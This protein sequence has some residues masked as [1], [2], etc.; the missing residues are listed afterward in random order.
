MSAAVTVG[1]PALMRRVERLIG[2]EIADSWKGGGD[3]DDIPEI[4]RE[5]R[6]ARRELERFLREGERRAR[7]AK[8]A[9]DNARAGL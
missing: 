9:L 2:A 5:L 6:L 1:R 7:G 8:I 4:E 3:P